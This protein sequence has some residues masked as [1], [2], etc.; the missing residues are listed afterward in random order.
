MET[1]RQT[2][3]NLLA[4][5]LWPVVMVLVVR[6]LGVGKGSAM[7]A[8]RIQGWVGVCMCACGGGG[9]DVKTASLLDRVN[10]THRP[11]VG[12][13]AS[14]KHQPTAQQRRRGWGGWGGGQG[15]KCQ[16]CLVTNTIL[17]TK[18]YIHFWGMGCLKQLAL[19]KSSFCACSSK[20]VAQGC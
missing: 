11:Q 12:S 20:P 13:K 16:P 17:G 14:L 1:V 15:Q 19:S 5:W 9:G 6:A 10:T 2:F 8:G 7:P 3:R 18:V 4:G